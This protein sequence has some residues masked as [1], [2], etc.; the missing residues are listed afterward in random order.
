MS[1]STVLNLVLFLPVIGIGLLLAVPSA[2]ADRIRWITFA[3][4]AA[5][6]FLTAWLYAHFDPLAPG[7]QFET[8]VPW[9][10]G[11]G[12]ARIYNMIE[13]RPDWTISRQRYWGVPIALFFSRETGEPDQRFLG[14]LLGVR[15]RAGSRGVAIG[16]QPVI[17]APDTELQG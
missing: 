1:E 17:P 4:M 14:K 16:W 10:P 3:V 2:R 5:Q 15:G 6:F 12:E 7:L 9:I 11:W 8:R 13:S